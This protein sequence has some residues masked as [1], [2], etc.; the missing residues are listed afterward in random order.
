MARLLNQRQLE[1]LSEFT[2]NMGLVFLA[3][4]TTPLFA[5][6]DERSTFVLLSGLLLT[7]GCLVISLFLLKGEQ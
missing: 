5:G 2:A 3:T 1:R 6:V 7:S 4:V